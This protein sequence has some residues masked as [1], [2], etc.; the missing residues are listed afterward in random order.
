[1]ERGGKGKT[2]HKGGDKN[3]FLS[4]QWL[5]N[6]ST[7]RSVH[8]CAV[9]HQD[10]TACRGNQ[11]P[12][13]WVRCFSHSRGKAEVVDDISLCVPAQA[14][15]QGSLISPRAGHTKVSPVAQAIASHDFD[16]STCLALWKNPFSKTM[17]ARFQGLFSHQ[18]RRSFQPWC[19]WVRGWAQMRCLLED[20]T[21]F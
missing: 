8:K 13:M 19:L 5:F 1:M 4:R 18:V 16:F 9:F 17:C 12:C 7:C 10:G 6:P 3:R 20:G 2:F 21:I 11:L 15:S 14:G